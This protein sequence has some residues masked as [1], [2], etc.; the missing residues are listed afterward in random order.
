MNEESGGFADLQLMVMDHAATFYHED[1]KVCAGGPP[2][3]FHRSTFEPLTRKLSGDSS[4][5]ILDDALK[6]GTQSPRGAVPEGKKGGMP[7]IGLPGRQVSAQ[8]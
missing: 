1:W 7:I 5:L 6:R 3:H 2:S 4:S 8:R